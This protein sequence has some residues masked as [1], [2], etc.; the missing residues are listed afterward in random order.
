MPG[1]CPPAHRVGLTV[2]AADD[3]GH[4]AGLAWPL[5]DPRRSSSGSCRSLRTC[6][7]ACGRTSMYTSSRKMQLRCATPIGRP[8]RKR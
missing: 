3:G 4:G 2:P 1:G 6:V 7:P 5:V 8:P